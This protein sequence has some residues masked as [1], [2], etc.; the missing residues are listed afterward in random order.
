MA[1]LKG[2][3]Q[4]LRDEQRRFRRRGRIRRCDTA[5]DIIQAIFSKYIGSRRMSTV[6]DD[7]EWDRVLW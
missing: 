4:E 5:R 6:P 1:D 7:P 3:L 2:E